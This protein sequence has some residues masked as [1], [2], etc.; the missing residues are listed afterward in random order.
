MPS[1]TADP[2]LNGKTT[3][4]VTGTSAKAEEPTTTLVKVEIPGINRQAINITLVGDSPLIMH[5]WSEKAKKAMLDKQMKKASQGKVAKDPKADFEGSIYYR[6][7][8]SYGFP[9]TGVKDSAVSSCRYIDGME[10]KM[11]FTKGAFHINEE[12]VKIEGTPEPREDMVRIAMGTADIRYRAE[13]KEW[14]TTFTVVY[15][16][17]VISEEQIVNLFNIGGFAVGVG[18]WRP[19]KGGSFGRYHV[20]LGIS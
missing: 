9:A 17:N 5:K 12:L 18:E 11:T 19:A 6:E 16:A 2:E 15:N 20:E 7:D 8:G 1:K 3:A 4:K 14:K 10:K 13:F